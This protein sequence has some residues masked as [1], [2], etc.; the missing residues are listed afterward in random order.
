MS[1]ESSSP[2]VA[3]PPP[4]HS[5]AIATGNASPQDIAP[6]DRL[7]VAVSL[8][9]L[10]SAHRVSRGEGEVILSAEH[11]LEHLPKAA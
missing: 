9:I 6:L 11:Y 4:L 2:S 5:E 1:H 3:L 10:A 8:V 7:V